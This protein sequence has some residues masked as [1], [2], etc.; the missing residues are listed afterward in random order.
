MFWCQSTSLPTGAVEQ[1]GGRLQ[2]HHYS[3]PHLLLHYPHRALRPPGG[4]LLALPVSIH[5]S[6]PENWSLLPWKQPRWGGRRGDCRIAGLAYVCSCVCMCVW[7][8]QKWLRRPCGW[9][10]INSFYVRMARLCVGAWELTY[11][12]HFTYIAHP[13][14][15]IALNAKLKKKKKS[16][17]SPHGRLNS[18]LTE[19]PLPNIRSIYHLL[20]RC[21]RGRTR[22][23]GSALAVVRS[24][25]LVSRS[26]LGS[27]T[28]AHFH[29]ATVP[30]PVLGYIDPTISSSTFPWRCNFQRVAAVLCSRLVRSNWSWIVPLNFFCQ[31]C[32]NGVPQVASKVC[33]A[34]TYQTR[35]RVRLETPALAD[36]LKVGAKPLW[37]RGKHRRLTAQMPCFLLIQVQWLVCD[38]VN[39]QLNFSCIV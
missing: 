1:E 32:Q 39:K 21:T 30:R 7:M 2:I 34:L 14:F 16:L 27:V 12:S 37:Q 29:S 10:W 3:T 13:V 8:R 15:R 25:L 4:G 31:P 33:D 35:V 18:T 20:T 22:G 26:E 5:L 36:R 38:H 6:A 23:S 9:I 11:D 17:V 19:L 28:Q 24:V